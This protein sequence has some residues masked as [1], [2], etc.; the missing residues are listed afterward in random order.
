M[1]PAQIVERIETSD[2]VDPRNKMLL[3]PPTHAEACVFFNKIHADRIS[4][5]YLSARTTDEPNNPR[6]LLSK[7]ICALCETRSQLCCVPRHQLRSV[8]IPG[9]GSLADSHE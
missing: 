9:R 1:L 4:S 6:V 5:I 3:P 2:P 8:W 7:R